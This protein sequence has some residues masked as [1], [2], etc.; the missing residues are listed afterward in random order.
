MPRIP[1]I[2]YGSTS[3]ASACDLHMPTPPRNSSRNGNPISAH[4]GTARV[5]TLGGI[6]PVESSQAWQCSPESG[7]DHQFAEGELDFGW[8]GG[9]G[10][11]DLIGVIRELAAVL[12]EDP[13]WLL[14]APS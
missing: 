1:I 13:R 11:G 5:R 2:L 10:T 3:S 6:D 7:P 4:T 8:W 14:R 9:H 12:L